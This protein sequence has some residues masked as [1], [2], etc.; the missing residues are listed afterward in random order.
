MTSGGG[1]GGLLAIAEPMI[2]PAASPPRTPAVPQPR[3]RASAEV[4]A[5]TVAAA[6]VL[7]AMK[8]YGV[9]IMILPRMMVASVRARS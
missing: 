2:A 4:G 7:A 6:I 9:R 5:A 8:A 3:Q 1:G